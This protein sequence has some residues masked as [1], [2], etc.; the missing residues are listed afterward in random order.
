M[1]YFTRRQTLNYQ[2]LKHQSKDMTH[3]EK[4]AMIGEY[5]DACTMYQI[6][7]TQYRGLKQDLER[8]EAHNARLQIMAKKLGNSKAT[9]V[10]LAIH[11]RWMNELKEKL[12]N[13]EIAY[14]HAGIEMSVMDSNVR[15]AG[16]LSAYQN[17]WDM[18]A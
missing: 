2:Q 7:E 14:K 17:W 9:N 13:T 18:Q 10:A 15:E 3:E 8:A 16:L 11:T 1:L 5:V 6:T 4:K 12:E